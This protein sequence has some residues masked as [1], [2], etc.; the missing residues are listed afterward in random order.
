[1]RHEPFYTLVGIF[2]VG[3]LILM[4]LG[5]LFFYE[6]Y[7]QAKVQTFVMFFKGSL[8]GLSTTAPVTY[9][10]VKIGEV[11]LIEIT[12]NKIK[13]KVE[14]PVYVEFFVEKS[15]AFAQN[16]VELLIR[17]GF[18]ADISKPNFLTGVSDIEL[19][20]TKVKPLNYQAQYFRGYPI[21]PTRNTKEKI[22]SIDDALKAA[23]IMIEEITKLVRSPA[24]RETLNSTRE[25]ANSFNQLA[26]NFDAYFPP[27]ITYF[28]RSMKEIA[29]AANSFQNLS[30]YLSRHP[31]SILRG[32][33]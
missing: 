13:N 1:M 32:K 9:R 25:M 23:Q 19:V 10:G 14:I 17:N 3:G 5:G 12:E 21:F 26:D 8:K 27:A 33:Q 24:V 15:L 4:F 20:K 2:V 11:S 6:Q 22:T 7:T 31:E 18:V 30:D 16:P 28:N 29:D